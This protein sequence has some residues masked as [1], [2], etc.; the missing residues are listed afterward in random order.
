MRS[1]PLPMSG[2]SI[3][4]DLGGDLPEE[5]RTALKA[6]VLLGAFFFVAVAAA[7]CLT[8][9]WGEPIPRDA[10][11]LVVGRD[12][13]NFW[14]YGRAAATADPGRFYDPAL[15]NE[16]LRALLGPNYFGHNWSYPPSV[17][18]IAAP[19]GRLPYLPGLLIWTALG[20][21][22]FIFIVRRELTDARVLIALVFSPAAVFCVISGQSSLLTAATLI[23][24]FACLDRRPVI[25]GILIGCLS[26]KPQLGLL[27]PVLLVAS[28]RWRTFAA[29]AT[30]TIAITV[31]TAILFGPQV[32]ID[33][34]QKGLPIQNE[35]MVD[36]RLL[37]APFMPTF[38]MNLRGAGAGYALAMAVQ[39][40]VAALAAVA[41]FWAYRF[42]RNADPQ[43]LAALFFACS[44][45]AVPYFL[46]YDLLPLTCAAVFLLATGKLDATGRRLAQLVYWLPLIQMVFGTLHVPGPA[47]IAPAFAVYV[48]MRL[49]AASESREHEP[50]ATANALRA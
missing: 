34:V 29:A 32:W 30:T 49:R 2:R 42:R 10:T 37:L 13:M 3:L 26:L 16:T 39:A 19:F 24:I 33:F 18:L 31:A 22:I 50:P 45:A 21:A 6:L 36:D 1:I 28:G 8:L 14:M 46:S 5:D 9:S 7:Y 15:Y 4:G 11:S 17:M 27:F 40:G 23:A 44:V 25:A 41:V 35:I 20:L 48:L 47:L 43:L 12:Y 38:F